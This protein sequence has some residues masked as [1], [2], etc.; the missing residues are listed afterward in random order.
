MD[1][2]DTLVTDFDVVDL[3]AGQTN[4]GVKVLGVLAAGVMLASPDG[5][6]RQ[7]ASSSE[8]MRILAI[9]D[10]AAWEGLYLAAAVQTGERG[11]RG[12]RHRLSAGF[13]E[14]PPGQSEGSPGGVDERASA[15]ARL[16]FCLRSLA[17]M[18]PPAS[19]R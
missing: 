9:F 11:D 6:L 16:S 10:P 18:P 13:P 19:D 2:A 12:Q 1:L 14:F 5:D 4:S 15:T 8:V 3:P 17:R 7:M